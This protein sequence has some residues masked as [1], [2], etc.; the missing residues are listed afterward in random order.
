MTT[1]AV[2][3]VESDYG[4][5]EMGQSSSEGAPDTY[6]KYAIW[7]NLP[8]SL[9]MKAQIALL[10][11]LISHRLHEEGP[12]SET[13]VQSA[14]TMTSP[15]QLSRPVPWFAAGTY[16]IATDLPV[17]D[18][19]VFG[20]VMGEWYDRA[21]HV[22]ENYA[23]RIEELRGYVQD[24]DIQVNAASEREFWSFLRSGPF[25][26]KASLVLLD[27]GN[28]R[29]VWNDNGRNHAGIQFLGNGMVQYVIFKRRPGTQEISRVAGR[30]TLEGLR[31][32]LQVFELLSLVGA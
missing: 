8:N 21:R 3:I 29:A 5:A 32:Q 6:G 12:W 27:N 28:L 14:L 18:F 17:H 15:G 11:L 24:D 10:K 25:V 26:R 31:K 16:D 13:P 19:R 30:D 22:Y 4:L 23:I 7:A 9:Q 20:P 2:T 1:G